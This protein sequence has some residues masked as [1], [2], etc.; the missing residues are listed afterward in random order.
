MPSLTHLAPK[1]WSMLRRALG[2]PRRLSLAFLKQSRA[3]LEAWRMRC[4][5]AYRAAAAGKPLP[6]DV[7]RQLA[8][9]QRVTA[10]HPETRTIHEGRVLTVELHAYRYVGLGLGLL[11]LW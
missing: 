1:E 10:R 3:H 4:R 8:V 9:G 11:A 7:P 6:P 2:R 5:A